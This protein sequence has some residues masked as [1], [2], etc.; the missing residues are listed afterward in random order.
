MK[1][2]LIKMQSINGFTAENVKA[3]PSFSNSIAILKRADWNVPND[4]TVTFN[5]ADLLGNGTNRVVFNVGG[6]NY[7]M[8]CKYNFGAKNTHLFIKW[9]GSHK[10]YTRLCEKREQYTIDK[11]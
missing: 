6:N 11:F 9:I 7:R 3:K 4:I 8:I 2:H 5:S 10:E 1:V